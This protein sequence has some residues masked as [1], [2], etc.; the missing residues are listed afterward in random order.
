LHGS[1]QL[2]LQL[3]TAVY[4]EGRVSEVKYNVFISFYF[5]L[6]GEIKTTLYYNGH[7]NRLPKFAGVLLGQLAQEN[8]WIM[9]G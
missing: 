8:S 5:I 6:G 1:K 4:E 9:D 3:L 7:T 2:Q